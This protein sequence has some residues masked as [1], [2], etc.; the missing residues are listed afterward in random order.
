MKRY[1]TDINALQA[2]AFRVTKEI[3]SHS[4][5]KD[6]YDML[7]QAVSLDLEEKADDYMASLDEEGEVMDIYVKFKAKDTDARYF[8]DY[9]F[10]PRLTSPESDPAH[11]WKILHDKNGG[12]AYTMPTVFTETMIKL[13]SCPASSA[14]IERWF[15]TVGF[16]WS[17]ERNRLGSEKALKLAQVYRTLRQPD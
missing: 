5:G 15:S 6:W 10:K 1:R 11:W 12:G 14:S 13:H 4:N 3:S 7:E 16:V 17:K 8:P 2:N 9:M